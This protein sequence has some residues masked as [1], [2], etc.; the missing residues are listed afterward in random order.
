MTN[1]LYEYLNKCA[2]DYYNG[3]PSL[4]DEAFDRLSDSCGFNEVGAKQHEHLDKH[5]YQMYSLQKIY[6]EEGKESPLRGRS[7]I[8]TSPK[9]DG[10]SLSLLYIEGKLV[11][12]LTRGNGIEGTN[13]TDKFLSSRFVPLE[14]DI[15]GVVQITG[16]IAAPNHIENARNYAAG[17][18]NLKNVDE[19]RTRAITFFAYGVQPY[20]A[21]YFDQDMGVL[22]SEGFNTVKDPDIQHIYP[23]DGVVHRLN[24]NKEFL[25]LG[26]TNSHPRGAY[27]LKQRGQAVET[28]LLNVEW[29][30]GKSGKITPVAILEPVLV[31]DAT[32]SRATLNNMAFIE[33]L[34]IKIGDTVAIER[35]GDVI[36]CVLYKVEQ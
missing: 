34:G 12:A 11:R 21:D 23:C 16:E 36:P 4:S 14:I 30:V 10:A 13:V 26:Y 31:G 6:A 15:M 22:S 3:E 27:A 33:A 32:V 5:L 28:K 19:F 2:R 24:S 25:E 9:L 8:D 18:L 1:K 20:I 35:A 7:E 29:Q 17:A